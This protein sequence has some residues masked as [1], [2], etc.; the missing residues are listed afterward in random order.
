RQG[1]V[2][3]SWPRRGIM[4]KIGVMDRWP[5]WG[6][7]SAGDPVGPRMTTDPGT[8]LIIDDEP[9]IRR[10]L[11]TTPA[12]QD[13]RGVEA[14]TRGEGR[15]RPP[16]EKPGLGVRERGP[17]DMDGLG[18]IRRIRDSSPLPIVV[19]SSRD[20]EKG[21]VAALD[22]GAD[23][24]VTKPFGVEELMARLRAALR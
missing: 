12:A 16:P 2:A 8:I 10:F 24:Y 14:A 9:P 4:V 3:R 7:P 22:L 20:D 17:R 1:V 23:D 11:R 5:G 18:L 6:P 21:K 13:Y 15:S 19:L